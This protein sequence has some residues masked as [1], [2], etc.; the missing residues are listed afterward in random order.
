VKYS[1]VIPIHN[2]EGSIPLLYNS[3]VSVLAAL[4]EGYEI[5]FVDDGS[6]DRSS[7]VLNLLPEPAT[8]AICKLSL[9]QGVL[10]SPPRSR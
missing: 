8:E 9:W 5:I 10:A 1:V 2:E 4:G 6:T 7:K 3:L